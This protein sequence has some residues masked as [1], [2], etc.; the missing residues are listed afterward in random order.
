VSSSACLFTS[1]TADAGPASVEVFGGTLSHRL[2]TPVVCGSLMACG[3]AGHPPA[4]VGQRDNHGV[5]IGV[6]NDRVVASAVDE[7]DHAPRLRPTAA[8]RVR[9]GAESER[10]LAAAGFG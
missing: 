6:D 8:R 3:P 9:P 10:T 2:P 7:H 5:T 1:L 4:Q